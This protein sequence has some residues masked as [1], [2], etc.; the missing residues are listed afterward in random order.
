MGR[1]VGRIEIHKLGLQ[2]VAAV[3]LVAAA[4]NRVRVSINGN[5]LLCHLN[6]ATAALWAKFRVWYACTW[7]DILFERFHKLLHKWRRVVHVVEHP[8]MFLCPS[9]AHIENAALLTKGVRVWLT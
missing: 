1:S 8:C 3:F 7:L 5:A 2:V 9:D 4:I 6:T